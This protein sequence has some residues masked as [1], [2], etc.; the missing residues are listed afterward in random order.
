[1]LENVLTVE[2]YMYLRVY[3]DLLVSILVTAGAILMSVKH[4]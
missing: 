4:S 3:R 2:Y 1:M